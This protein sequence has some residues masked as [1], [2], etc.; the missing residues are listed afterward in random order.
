MQSKYRILRCYNPLESA[1]VGGQKCMVPQPPY[2]GASAPVSVT[3]G[4]EQTGIVGAAA[5]IV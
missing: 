2:S 5:K 3:D 1:R 4:W